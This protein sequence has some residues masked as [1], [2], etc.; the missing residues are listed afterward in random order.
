MARST[1]VQTLPV[2]YLP[3]AFGGVVG[4]AAT[5]TALRLLGFDLQTAG[6]PLGLH[7]PALFRVVLYSLWA[8]ITAL[9]LV[10]ILRQRGFGPEAL[11]WQG[12]LDVRTAATAAA[13]AGA[14]V[15]LWLPVD[16][17]RQALG[18]PVYWDPAQRG[19][20]RPTTI[21]EFVAAGVAGLIFVP[22]A[23]ETIF[24]GYVL[25][26]LVARLGVWRGLLVHNAL[27]ALYHGGIGPGLPLYIFVWSF[28]P[29]L[30]L[31]RYRSLYPAILMHVL[32]NVWV[33]LLV[34]LLFG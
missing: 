31:I 5:L 17:V 8:V 21:W 15:V 23:E 9:V 28:F 19:F 14:A 6:R 12:T 16:A 4:T 22:L 1:T 13:F 33:D 34:P 30:L 10:R 18:V 32:N 3:L 27:F 2:G 7:D 26:A 11:G 25:Q 20:I 29:A 24:R